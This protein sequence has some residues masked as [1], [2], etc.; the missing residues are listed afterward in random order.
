M[1]GPKILQ[2]NLQIYLMVSKS[3]F[4]GYCS[5]LKYGKGLCKEYIPFPFSGLSL[6]V[7]YYQAVNGILFSTFNIEDFLHVQPYQIA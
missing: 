6:I 1:K 3:I 2:K 4:Y 7:F 5:A